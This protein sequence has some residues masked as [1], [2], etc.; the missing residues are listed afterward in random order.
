VL[1]VMR[2]H[3]NKISAPAIHPY[4]R[5]VFLTRRLRG[6]QLRNNRGRGAMGTRKEVLT[7]ERLLTAPRRIF[8][9]GITLNARPA[10]A[11]L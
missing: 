6:G 4:T 8:G 7:N 5:N 11:L 1:R 3:A 2:R 10:R 9:L